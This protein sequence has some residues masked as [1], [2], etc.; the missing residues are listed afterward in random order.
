M[1]KIILSLAVAAFIM[2]GSVAIATTSNNSETLEIVQD[3]KK[4]AKT[5]KATKKED[6][7][8]KNAKA[9][10]KDCDSKVGKKECCSHGKTTKKKTTSPEKK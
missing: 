8:D 5:T 2:S 3:G 6:C 4:K 10:K 1:K 9:T 7:G